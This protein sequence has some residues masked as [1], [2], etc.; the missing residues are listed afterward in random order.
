MTTVEIDCGSVEWGVDEG[1]VQ[2]QMDHDLTTTA[3]VVRRWRPNTLTGYISAYT[4]EVKPKLPEHSN[5]HLLP[6]RCHWACHLDK[7]LGK[8]SCGFIAQASRLSG[9]QE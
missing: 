9:V 6:Y 8:T 5:Q 4:E 1:L 2:G 7:L 3:V